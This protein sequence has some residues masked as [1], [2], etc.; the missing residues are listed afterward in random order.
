MLQ[1]A[2]SA[3]GRAREAGISRCTLRVFLPRGDAGD[4]CPTDESWQGGIMQLYKACSPLVRDLIKRISTD[5]AGVPP[6]LTEQRLDA[7]GVDG[8][9]AWF[10]QS[11]N[12]QNDMTGLVQPS[13]EQM[14]TIRTLSGE[15]GGRLLMLINPQWKACTALSPILP[16]RLPVSSC[17]LS[18]V[19]MHPSRPSQERDDPFDALSRK[20]GLLGALGKA[21]GGKAAREEEV[22]HARPPPRARARAP[23]R[24]ASFFAPYFLTASAP[25]TDC[26]SSA[27]RSSRRWDSSTST[28]WL[29]TSAEALALSCSSP[30]RTDGPRA[31]ATRRPIVGCPC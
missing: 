21:L 27:R 9:S 25:L 10:A 2:A 26:P 16:R 8:E 5:E 18:E 22:R 14:G 30:T 4:L 20:Q 3:I 19:P 29:S 11:A 6:A 31:T 23:L 12:P 7:S 13:A 28:R 15:A 24:L 17:A 1:Q